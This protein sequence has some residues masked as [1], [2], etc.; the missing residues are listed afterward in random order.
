MA[1]P[2][3]SDVPA[4]PPPRAAQPKQWDCY[5]SVATA[6]GIEQRRISS[7]EISRATNLS[8][9]TLG[10]ILTFLQ[11]VGLVVGS[12]GA[13]AV[14]RD[15]WAIAKTWREDNAQGRLLLQGLFLARW[16][17]RLAYRLLCDGP[18]AQHEFVERV[19]G[20]GFGHTRRVR[21]LVDWLVMALLVHR[22]AAL[23]VS[24]SSALLASAQQWQPVSALPSQPAGHELREGVLMGMTHSELRALPPSHYMT[25]LKN[26]ASLSEIDAAG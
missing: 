9:E 13:Y 19:G 8:V 15:G 6:S 14:T 22:D 23:T 17:A 7:K 5:L 3:G 10:G 20:E 21:Y 25:V 18:V 26:V 4:L 11:A 12:R 2:T 1:N 24:A 16:P